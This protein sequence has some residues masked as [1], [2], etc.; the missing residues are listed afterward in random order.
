MTSI[1]EII[2]NVKYTFSYKR[3][4]IN[5]EK[6]LKVNDFIIFRSYLQKQS[7][8]QSNEQSFEE[9]FGIV[10]SITYNTSLFTSTREINITVEILG[11]VN[12]SNQIIT[13]LN[14]YGG[15]IV[16]K[17]S[18]LDSF[19]QY[20]EITK[21]QLIELCNSIKKQLLESLKK[22]KS[23][24]K[25]LNKSLNNTKSI[26]YQSA[27][28]KYIYELDTYIKIIELEELKGGTK[29]TLT[30]STKKIPTKKPITKKIPTKK[31][32]TK[33]I[34]IKKIPTKKIP[35]KKIP[36]KK[37]PTKKIPTKK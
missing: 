5:K 8:K 20:L 32:P 19:I 9:L 16:I 1:V 29:K 24:N 6:T 13:N 36:T 3:E 14:I 11:V 10:K 7:Y 35:I 37:I 17:Q 27:Y 26:N 21:K 18:N 30:S 2:R 31:I 23:M 25:I 15:T 34:P 4:G 12:S 33:K 22:K 28:Q